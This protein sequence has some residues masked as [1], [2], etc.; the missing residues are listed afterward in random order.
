M[1]DWQMHRQPAE[2]LLS[3]VML[4]AGCELRLGQRR[5]R[6]EH[7]LRELHSA[8]H[9]RRG[10]QGERLRFRP[11]TLAFTLTAI[12][13]QDSCREKRHVHDYTTPTDRRALFA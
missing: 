1:A 4:A 3:K 2:L 13:S 7:L 10:R 9:L 6:G 8:E 5:L 12:S 11:V